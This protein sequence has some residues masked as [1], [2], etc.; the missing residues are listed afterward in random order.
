MRLL[1]TGLI[2]TFS[3]FANAAVA[4]P[5]V[6]EKPATLELKGELGGRVDGTPWSSTELNKDVFVMFYV[7]PDEKG[8]NEHVEK[9]M[10]DANFPDEAYK[11]VAIINMDATWLPNAAIASS[12]ESKQEEYPDTVYVKDMEKTVVK[13]WAFGDDTYAIAIF[14]REGILQFY[15]DGK[16]SKDEVK[17]FIGKLKDVTAPVAPT[18]QAKPEDK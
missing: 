8:I 2:A 4:K 12:L 13:K 5:K 16:F 7:D 15:N 10:T 1:I 11:T 6:G 3:L 18:P 14:D 17:K 9:A